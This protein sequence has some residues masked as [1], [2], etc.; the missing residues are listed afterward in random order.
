[1]KRF[2]VGCPSLFLIF[3]VTPIF[4]KSEVVKIQSPPSV[5]ERVIALKS[6]TIGDTLFG[7]KFVA[8]GTIDCKVNKDKFT[9]RQRRLYGNAF[10]PVLYGK[11]RQM[12]NGTEISG[13]FRMHS[14]VFAFL[15]VW[16]GVVLLGG[17]I[18]AV[19]GLTQLITGHNDHGK[20]DNPLL[21]I[22]GPVFMLVMGIAVVKFGKLFGRSEEIKMASFLQE[23]F[24]EKE[25][26]SG[27]VSKSASKNLL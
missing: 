19:T 4:K 18:L 8:S 1:M 9:L 17:G 10:G 22:F 27:P 13:E 2:L 5:E 7:I 26:S 11:L 23:L 25:A 24:A 20:N 6:A 3:F 15:C 12:D 21:G 14:I 16:F